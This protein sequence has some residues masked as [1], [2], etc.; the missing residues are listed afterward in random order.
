VKLLD[1]FE[2]FEA[3]IKGASF[4][5]KYTCFFK[6]VKKTNP[7]TV[8][9]EDLQQYIKYLQEKFPD[10]E[11]YLRVAKVGGRV[12]HVITRKCWM[13]MPD[14]ARKR[15]SDRVPIY[16]DVENQKFYIP[17]SYVEKRYKLTCYIVMRTLGKLGVS[18]VEYLSTAPS[19]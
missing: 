14:G 16:V 7:K 1:V 6:I 18:T 17:K 8:T 15:V 3:V 10:R 4:H 9:V 19:I 5:S 2:D 12:F 11:F 13:K